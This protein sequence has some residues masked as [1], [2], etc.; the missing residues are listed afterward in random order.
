MT[1]YVTKRYTVE[2]VSHFTWQGM[3]VIT[4]YG[5][6]LPCEEILGKQLVA[7]AVGRIQ[8]IWPFICS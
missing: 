1:G 6:R 4:S 2:W 7:Q 5:Q 8:N 3:D